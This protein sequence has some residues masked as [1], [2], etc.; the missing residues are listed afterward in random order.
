MNTSNL[1]R[2]FKGKDLW[3]NF[4]LALLPFSA[5]KIFLQDA[6]VALPALLSFPLFLAL[7]WVVGMFLFGLEKASS[8]LLVHEHQDARTPKR[9]TVL[10]GGIMATLIIVAVVW[11]VTALPYSSSG[12]EDVRWACLQRINYSP[13]GFY[14]LSEEFTNDRTF[15]TQDEALKYCILERANTTAR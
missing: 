12:D 11:I 14:I 15:K 13:R 6:G 5:T 9:K 2:P 8:H 3:I 7:I 10:L 1:L 4:F